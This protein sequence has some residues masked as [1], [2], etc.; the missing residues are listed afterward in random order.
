MPN[1]ISLEDLARRLGVSDQTIRRYIEH[2]SEYLEVETNEIGTEFSEKTADKFLRI[3]QILKKPSY[4]EL[5][6]FLE[7]ETIQADIQA[8]TNAFQDKLTQFGLSLS[9]ISV[10]LSV[11][12]TVRAEMERPDNQPGLAEID[13]HVKKI[14][15]LSKKI[16][17]ELRNDRT[18]NE[19][20]S[21]RLLFRL[22]NLSESVDKLVMSEIDEE[23]KKKVPDYSHEE[24]FESG[25]ESLDF[26]YS[27]VFPIHEKIDEI[28]N[29][30]YGLTW[31]D[32]LISDIEYRRPLLTIIRNWEQ[33]LMEFSGYPKRNRLS[34]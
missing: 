21:R 32:N 23:I 27:L 6:S 25:S 34:W 12:V 26:N 28:R 30:I 10:L 8:R 4:D 15:S 5:K 7:S 22:K 31:D 24:L 11:Y 20:I 17:G 3:R 14:H 13:S 2:F 9:G 1:N 19:G 29:I 18:E 33:D 16:E